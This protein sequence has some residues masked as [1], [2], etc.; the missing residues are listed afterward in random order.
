MP[1]TSHARTSSGRFCWVLDA[2]VVYRAREDY[3]ALLLLVEIQLHDTLAL[4]MAREIDD[5]YSPALQGDSTIQGW[6]YR[7]ITDGRFERHDSTLPQDC[8]KRLRQL[9]FHDDDWK[10]VGVAMRTR[11]HVIVTEDRGDHDFCPDV[12]SYLAHG[13]RVCTL[14]VH[15]ACRKARSCQPRG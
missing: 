10:Y 2:N 9:K 8:Q 7:I 15:D 14:C 13:Y 12:C 1:P 5:E 11:D 6:F 3:E 4:D